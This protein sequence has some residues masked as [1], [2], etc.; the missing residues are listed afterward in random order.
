MVGVCFYF[1]VHQPY[2][3]KK[4][5]VFDIGKSSDYFDDEKNKEIMIK[6]AKK[7]YIPMTELLL[8]LIKKSNGKFR[9]AFSITG[10]ALDQ[11]ESYAPEVINN[12][13]KLAE[14]G[15]VE[16]LS[17]TYYH[18]LSFL[19]THEEF[20]EQVNMHK[21]KIKKLFNVVPKTFRN[22]ELIFS[23]DIALLIKEMGFKGVLAEGADH[24]LDWRSPNF[25]YSCLG[26]PELPL[27]LKNYKLS[28]DIAFRFSDEGWKEWPL[29]VPKYVSWVNQVNGNGD[30]INLFMDFETFGEHQW[31][32]KGIFQFMEHLP[33]EILKHPDN[34]FLTP[35]EVIEKYPIRAELNFPYHVSWADIERDISAW[36]GNKIQEDSLDKL[37][38]LEKN[39]KLTKDKKLLEEWRKLTTSDHFYYMC[40]KWFN[41]GDVHK[42]FNPYDS[43][44]D[45]FIAFMNI[46]QDIELRIQEKL[47]NIKKINSHNKKRGGFDECKTRQEKRKKECCCSTA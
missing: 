36:K 11:F 2:R 22:T 45:S 41:D 14:T 33:S 39:I 31:E 8:K 24:I 18:S 1:Q 40:T 17:E 16:F 30:V 13:K 47:S 25:I 37:Y 12:F 23:N 27:L 28:D 34:C 15:C 6:V 5:H 32:D 44:Y 43:P 35:S 10:I 42:Y 26:T 4:Y 29:T 46:L 20:K 21:N 19:Y 7:C 3:M 38:S 9:F